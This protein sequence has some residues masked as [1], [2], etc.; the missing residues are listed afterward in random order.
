VPNGEA[1]L[2]R[3][4][5][6]IILY[7]MEKEPDRR[8]QNAEALIHDLRCLQGAPADG[9]VCAFPLGVHDFARRHSPPSRPVGRPAEIAQPSAKPRS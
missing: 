9:E 7:L 6:E 5:S 8:Y 2:P 1:T 4:L 3:A